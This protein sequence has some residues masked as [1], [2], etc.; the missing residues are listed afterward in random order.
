M[1]IPELRKRQ[2]YAYDLVVSQHRN[3]LIN[4]KAGTG[5]T[6]LEHAIYNGL[7]AQGYRSLAVA[8]T[9]K[10]A[11]LMPNGTT[12][13]RASAMKRGEEDVLPGNYTDAK[14]WNNTLRSNVREV[15]PNADPAWAHEKL[16]VFIDEAG[17]LSSQKARL[18]Y[19]IGMR[20]RWSKGVEQP[21]IFV[22]CADFGQL[23]CI[24]G[25][26]I[27]KP[28]VYRYWKTRNEEG[29][30]ELPSLLDEIKAELVVLD[31]VV[32]QDD[33]R[34]IRALDWMYFGK[35]LHPLFKERLRQEPPQYAPTVYFN[36]K[37][38]VKENE[39]FVKQFVEQNPNAPYKDYKA[40]GDVLSPSDLRSL[41]P[42]TPT[43]RVYQGMPFT[44]TVN[45]PDP[46]DPRELLAA[47][48][49][50]VTVTALNRSG[51]T[52]T[53][54]NGDS[55]DLGMMP[56]WFPKP[57]TGKGIEF[58]QLPGYAG[59]AVS[60]YKCQ[61]AT[62]DHP[63]TF[64]AWQWLRNNRCSLEN[65]PGSTYVMCSRNT[66]VED[67]YF[68]TSFG[69]SEA[70][71][72]LAKAASNCN[73]EV[74]KFLLQGKPPLWRQDPMGKWVMV[75]LEQ[76]ELVDVEGYRCLYATFFTTSL[77][78]GSESQQRLGFYLQGEDLTL[79]AGEESRGG[80]TRSLESLDFQ[81]LYTDLA[82]T[83]LSYELSKNT[84][85]VA[86]A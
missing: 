41:E 14:P 55:V 9:G 20:Y 3:V 54:S 11:S 51:I 64:A 10:A 36:N 71:R 50:T 49:E 32:R 56:H 38:V 83:W 2:Q 70:E 44:I 17:Q 12:A 7:K 75:E 8:F 25:D 43:M 77:Q 53:R 69:V 76:A 66:R 74:L 82:K 62:Y 19:D 39:R 33:P 86:A 68:D 5:K 18:F 24:N 13:S 45:V 60:L 48:G 21:P 46:Q 23:N 63:T 1:E 40:Y 42:V 67:L 16:V 73:E 15:Y 22:I 34:Y 65:Q 4:G 27:F 37:E 57:V 26:L 52:A 28:A 59:C 61:G 35:G 78:D 6:T 84:Q 72:L 81:S 80:Q 29:V 79:F 47:N 58:V 31:E 85:L 30:I